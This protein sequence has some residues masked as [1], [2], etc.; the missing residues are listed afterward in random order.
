LNWSSDWL[1]A[2]ASIRIFPFF[3]FSKQAGGGVLI[4][5]NKRTQNLIVCTWKV[6]GQ[7]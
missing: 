5:F 2:G 7:S 4:S 1:A 3:N 6:F